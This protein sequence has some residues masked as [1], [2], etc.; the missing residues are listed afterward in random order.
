ME[1]KG[2]TECEALDGIVAAKVTVQSRTLHLLQ[3]P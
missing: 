2:K 3:G 1:N